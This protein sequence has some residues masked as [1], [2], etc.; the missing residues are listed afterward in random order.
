MAAQNMVLNLTRLSGQDQVLDALGNRWQFMQFLCLVVWLARGWLVKGISEV[1]RLR[2][3]WLYLLNFNQKLRFLLRSDYL[4][5]GRWLLEDVLRG[6]DTHRGLRLWRLASRSKLHKDVVSG[7]CEQ[8]LCDG[9]GIV[10]HLFLISLN[11]C[12]ACRACDGCSRTWH[13]W[14]GPAPQTC[15]WCNFQTMCKTC[16]Q[17]S[18]DE[19][20]ETRI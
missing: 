14:F 11:E 1:V 15:P 16:R 8:L 6:A 10:F 3:N 18:T 5:R 20:N 12:P 17:S 7:Y 13:H 9:E 19:A 2:F 4:L